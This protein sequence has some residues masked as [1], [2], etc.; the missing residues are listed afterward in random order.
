MTEKKLTEAT[1]AELLDEYEL[2][3]VKEESA[4]E[5]SARKER[6]FR[7][8]INAGGAWAVWGPYL[9]EIEEELRKRGIHPD[10]W[11]TMDRGK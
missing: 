1:N 9:W 11:V 2:I 10:G 5:G 7:N 6:P 8:A 4:R 3:R